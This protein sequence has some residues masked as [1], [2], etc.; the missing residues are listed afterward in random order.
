MSKSAIAKHANSEDANTKI[1]METSCS[2]DATLGLFA[3]YFS[4]PGQFLGPDAH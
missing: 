2:I 1:F 4:I 3:V